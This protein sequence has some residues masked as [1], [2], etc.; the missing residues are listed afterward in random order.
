MFTFGVAKIVYHKE[1]YQRSQ[2]TFK[3]R[4]YELRKEQ[5]FRPESVSASL[6]RVNHHSS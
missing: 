3:D 4:H 1:G 5:Y 2:S 6:S